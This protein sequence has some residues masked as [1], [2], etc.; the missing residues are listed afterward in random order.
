MRAITCEFPLAG[1]LGPQQHGEAAGVATA[2]DVDIGVADEPDVGAGPHQAAIQRQ[3]DG[4]D[5][6]LVAPGVAGADQ[7][8]EMPGPVEMFGLAAEHRALFVADHR[9][10][11]A[12]AGQA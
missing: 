11:E 5:R 3:L 7:P 9:E 6:G 8:A 12:A 10:I 2:L 1:R 4:I